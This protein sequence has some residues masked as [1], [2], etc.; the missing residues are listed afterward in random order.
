MSSP[1]KWFRKNQKLLLGVFGVL[2]VFVFTI[3]LGSGIDPIVNAITGGGGGGPQGGA[4]ANK[5]V[6]TWDGGK[7]TELEMDQL[8]LRRRL[9]RRFLATC[10]EQSSRRGAIPSGLNIPD[11]D[12][13]ESIVQT[14]ILAGRAHE[15]GIVIDDATI[16]EALALFTGGQVQPGEL[17]MILDRSTNEQMSQRQLFA[18]LRD[19]L[20]AQR[21]I[22]ANGL[23]TFPS[24]TAS[25][26]DF[27]NRLRR[28]VSAELL[29]L[30]VAS[31]LSQVEDPTD[32]E[33]QAF[34]NE[35]KEDFREPD[36]PE[37]GFRRR[38]QRSFYYVKFDFEAFQDQE[39]E[40]VTADDI[41]EY[42]DENKDDFRSAELPEGSV[43]SGTTEADSA[44]STIPNISDL[45]DATVTDPNESEQDSSEETIE[46]TSGG[47]IDASS[48]LGNDETNTETSTETAPNETDNQESIDLESNEQAPS[49]PEPATDENQQSLLRLTSGTLLAQADT[50][51]AQAD[52]DLEEATT[53]ET[54]D[55][56]DDDAT[57][58]NSDD[59]SIGEAAQAEPETVAEPSLEDLQDDSETDEPS[60][61]Q[62]GLPT[63]E[64]DD[65][66]VDLDDLSEETDSTSSEL[67]P[68]ES[69]RGTDVVDGSDD[70]PEYKPLE[71]VR[72][73][74]I[75]QLTMQPAQKEFQKA[76]DE[77]KEAMDSYHSKYIDWTFTRQE[78]PDASRPPVPSLDAIIANYPGVTDGSTPLMDQ[79][80]IR[81]HESGL[82]RATDFAFSADRQPIPVS[83]GSIAYEGQ[84]D[85]YRPRVF[86][87]FANVRYVFWQTDQREGGVP[88]LDD[89]MRD[90]VA[91]AIKMQRAY[92][93][94]RKDAEQLKD[95]ASQN[96][97]M[98][99]S[100][101]FPDKETFDVDEL[102]WMSAGNL[103]FGGGR[104]SVNPIPGVESSGYQ[105]METLFGLAP[106]EL[107]VISN[108]PQTAVYVVRLISE[109]PDRDNLQTQFLQFGV[110]VPVDE[111]AGEEQRRLLYDWYQELQDQYAVTWN[112]EPRRATPMN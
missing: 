27:F 70:Q 22:W 10:Y 58:D 96:V 95:Q 12:S 60:A 74:I 18:A 108:Q 82:G 88:E 89:E 87:S 28:T 68:S 64:S 67:G 43:E 97:G 112:R 78:A 8:R 109:S 84:G 52:T 99:L 5:V 63:H 26:W 71:E 77:V 55:A 37:P 24:S 32:S 9:L 56:S 94:A 47:P 72:D 69:D 4:T 54:G 59:A 30:D 111:I 45:E 16:L 105:F 46:P 80:E 35:Y 48:D 31:Y 38:E 14:Q 62:N 86:P 7:L 34:F 39:K 13:D 65:I 51:L 44:S 2:L 20:L 1:F 76:I 17:A 90:T 104:V 103:G 106:G 50:G 6:V 21:V 3:S 93:K 23:G 73:E 33:I 100:E 61:A 102:T 92:E 85:L 107:S 19:E 36:S 57:V 49:E 101:L 25:A 29:K 75:Q 41:Q 79:F 81:D 83:F 42:Y 11:S 91:L 98:P 110:T 15:L 53:E 66:S 40:S